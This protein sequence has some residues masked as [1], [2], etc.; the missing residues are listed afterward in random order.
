[1]TF[2]GWRLRFRAGT[3]Q[4][5]RFLLLLHG[6]SGDE[7]SM[8]VFVRGFPAHY[9][10]AAPRAPHVAPQGG[11]SWR[12]PSPGARRMPKL[13]DMRPSAE[14]LIRFVDDFTASIGVEAAQFEALGFSQ[15][16]AMVS[17]LALLFPQ[18]I[19][20]AGVLAGFVPDGAEGQIARR[21]LQGKP[22]FVAHGVQDELVPLE[23]ARRSVALLEQAGARVT[24]CEADLGHK[25]G[26]Q[27]LR[28][29][30]EFFA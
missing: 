2:N 1:M 5:P 10:I 6:W 4:P 27:C 17:A 29:L 26:A 9:W 13:E 21:V 16:A 12:A 20:R 8:W 30:G 3:Q 28:A 18:R 19:R 24:Y 25:V 11:Y 23:Q 7:N 22:F 15:G 14:G